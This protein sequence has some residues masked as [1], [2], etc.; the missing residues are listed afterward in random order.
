MK[1]DFFLNATLNYTLSSLQRFPKTR[2][3][4][5]LFTCIKELFSFLQGNFRSSDKKNNLRTARFLFETSKPDFFSYCSISLEMS[6]WAAVL[7]RTCND[8]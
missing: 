2:V 1:A 6:V 7:W 8:C 3:E 4:S 5:A